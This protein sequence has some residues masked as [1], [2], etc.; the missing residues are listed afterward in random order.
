MK[1]TFEEWKNAQLVEIEHHTDLEHQAYIP[2]C[3]IIAEYLNID[4]KNDF[5]DKIIVEVGAGPKGS[6]LL[7]EGNFKEAYVVEPLIEK[8]PSEIR[9]SYEQIGVKIITQPYELFDIVYADET[10]LYNVLQHVI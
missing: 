7:T 2:A 3:N 6:V 9:S 10:W 4:Y 1:I 8:W 5:K